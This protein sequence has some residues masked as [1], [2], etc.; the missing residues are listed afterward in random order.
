MIEGGGLGKFKPEDIGP[1]DVQSKNGVIDLLVENEKDATQK[2]KQLLGYFK[3]KLN[4][5]SS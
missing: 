1:S 4:M 3:V 5:S 2:A